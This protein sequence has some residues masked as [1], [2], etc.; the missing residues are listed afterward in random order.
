[1]FSV[2][3]A[4][5][6]EY[7]DVAIASNAELRSLPVGLSTLCVEPARKTLLVEMGQSSLKTYLVTGAA[8]FIG[9]YV[10]LRLLARGDSVLALDN[11]NDYYD[12]KLKQARLNRILESPLSRNFKFVKASLEDSAVIRG[13]FDET[14]FDGVV[15]LAAQAGVRYSLTKPHAYI[16]SNITGFL[17]VLEGMRAQRCMQGFKDDDRGSG[18]HM[19]YA[20]S[21][22]V[23]GGNK[24]LPFEEAQSVDLPISLYA[25][26]KRANELMGHTY[27]HLFGIPMTGLRF[28]TVYGPW[29]R[30]DMAAFKFVKAI[31]DGNPIEVYNHGNMRRDFTFVDDIVEGVIR[32]LGCPPT[33]E[34]SAGSDFAFEKLAAHRV[35]NIGNHHPE[36]L[37]EFISAIEDTLGIK[38]KRNL[39]PIQPGDVPETYAS[40]IKLKAITGFS[41]S[42]PLREGVRKFVEW[43][44]DYYL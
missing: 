8:G 35:L 33:A 31:L 7:G 19:V 39:L 21:S 11:L 13:L 24:S 41:P 12:P 4:P 15:H 28:F 27:S 44:R 30:P 26:T 1:M 20:S 9:H 25:A 36:C 32:V 2:R 40:N 5:R 22:S 17:S 16:D 3:E 29:G 10:A 43:Y 38:A 18:P 14:P 6:L 42:T 37:T 34:D 23:Y